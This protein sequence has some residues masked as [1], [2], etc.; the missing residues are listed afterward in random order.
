M[1]KAGE[2]DEYSRTYTSCQTRITIRSNG[3]IGERRPATA[4]VNLQASLKLRLII[5]SRFYCSGHVS[6]HAEM[7]RGCAAK[8][9]PHIPFG[10]DQIHRCEGNLCNG[11]LKGGIRY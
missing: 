3:W 7:Y 11:K 4:L 5:I 6:V 10:S 8:G 2:N 1:E 9:T